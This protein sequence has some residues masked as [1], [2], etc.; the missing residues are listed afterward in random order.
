MKKG[1]FI[2][3]LLLFVIGINNSCY[4]APTTLDFATMKSILEELQISKSDTSISAM[5]EKFNAWITYQ[6]QDL[7][8]DFDLGN[9]LFYKSAGELNTLKFLI[10]NMGR[11]SDD[12]QHLYIDTSQPY[13]S[14]NIWTSWKK[15]T[16]SGAIVGVNTNGVFSVWYCVESKVDLLG[17]IYIDNDSYGKM[18]PGYT[19]NNSALYLNYAVTYPGG[20]I[21]AKTQSYGYNTYSLT[22]TYDVSS[23]MPTPTPTA[24]PT[25]TP[26]PT[27]SGGGSTPSGTDLTPVIGKL[28]KTNKNLEEIK[29]NIPTSGDIE[30]ATTEGTI[31]GNTTYWGNSGDVNNYDSEKEVKDIIDNTISSV[32]G[33]MSK[34]EAI[35]ILEDA[36]NQFW[37]RFKISGNPRN[38]GI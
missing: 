7:N 2:I 18:K 32:S 3:S 37:N 19:N 6:T 11:G 28:D 23:I 10:V 20:L 17:G 25:V 27:P 26:T 14:N 35:K 8:K 29:N 12:L 13:Y 21:Y 34:I 9:I 5:V 38:G 33:E 24:T 30:K 4:A 16:S 15:N 31:K 36:E 22:H 1:I